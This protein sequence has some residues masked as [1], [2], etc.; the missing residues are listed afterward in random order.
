MAK[1]KKPTAPKKK[2]VKP[3]KGKQKIITAKRPKARV[4]PKRKE[5]V[6]AK[7]KSVQS[8]SPRTDSKKTKKRLKKPPTKKQLRERALKGWETRR[9]FEQLDPRRVE[10]IVLEEIL[11]N[12]VQNMR[13]GELLMELATFHMDGSKAKEPSILRHIDD[14]MDIYE[15]LW[16]TQSEMSEGGYVPMSKDEIA[17]SQQFRYEAQKIAW[18]YEVPLR[19]VYTLFFS[20]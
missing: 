15:R 5:V 13:T 3:V 20:P 4:T 8:G 18:D 16:R 12:A 6:R 2:P 19:E 10:K 1:R 14:T 9:K 17:H 11:P 7:K